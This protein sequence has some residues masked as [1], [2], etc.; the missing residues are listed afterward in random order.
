MKIILQILFVFGGLNL[1]G[2]SLTINPNPFIQRTQVCYTL[3]TADTITIAIFNRWGQ[4]ILTIVSNSITP[5]GVY[6]DSLIMD[7]FDDGVYVLSFRSKQKY[8]LGKQVIKSISASIQKVVK[9]E[10]VRIYPNPVQGALTIETFGLKDKKLSISNMLGQ[11]VM[12]Y[13]GDLNRAF[14]LS[15]FSSGIYFFKIDG[16]S[17][18]Y[19][20]IKVN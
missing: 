3:T 14:D 20:I 2:Q 17:S 1:L 16:V 12:V 10:R 19:K 15:E 5:A 6:C 7:S 11:T 4:Q 18:T 9:E 13:E 8:F